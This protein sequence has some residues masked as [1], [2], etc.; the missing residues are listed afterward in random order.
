MIKYYNK[1]DRDPNYIPELKINTAT[2]FPLDQIRFRD[3]NNNTILNVFDN[4]EIIKRYLVTYNSDRTKIIS[5]RE[6]QRGGYYVKYLKY[7]NKYLT[8]KNMEF[9]IKKI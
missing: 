2:P 6:E 3:F 7:K 5:Y 4:L 9:L 8:L 1:Y